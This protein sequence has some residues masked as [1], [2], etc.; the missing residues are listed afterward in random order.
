[1][2]DGKSGFLQS[3]DYLHSNFLTGIYL[4]SI[5]YCLLTHC[6]EDLELSA[7]IFIFVVLKCIHMECLHGIK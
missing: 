7:V 2:F 1:M 3:E 6:F 5:I 4:T